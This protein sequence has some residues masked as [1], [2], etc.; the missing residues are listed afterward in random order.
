M[1]VLTA[2]TQAVRHP[3]QLQGRPGR[4]RP[5][6]GRSAPSGSTLPKAAIAD[7][8][9]AFRTAVN[10]RRTVV[11]SLPLDVQ[12]GVATDAVSDGRHRGR[13]RIR[14]DP[15]SVREL[16][17]LLR[18]A[19]R[20]VFIA[21]RG[22]RGARQEILALAEHSGALVG[23]LRRRERPLQRRTVQ[24]GHLRRLLLAADGRT[25][26]RGRPHCW[27]GL[28]AEYVDHAPRPPDRRRH[29]GGPGGRRGLRRWAPT[30]PSIWAC[31]AIRD[32]QR[33]D[34]LTCHGSRPGQATREVPHR[35]KTPK[36]IAAQ[37]RWTG[38]TIR[39]TSP[40]PGS[41]TR[42]S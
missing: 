3:L 40:R 11:L 14:P 34:A 42:G 21:G 31:W 16:V 26:Q 19:E 4:S 1:I 24:P 6:C 30:A 13:L 32:W 10:E 37:S 25:D 9:R 7:T 35:S 5:Q 20:P 12:A 2:D 28:H 15:Q 38:R 22:G 39:W 29:Q 18:A 36:A 8:V 41:S 23:N 17:E 27:L 33:G